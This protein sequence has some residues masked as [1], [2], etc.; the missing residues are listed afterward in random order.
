MSMK[1]NR[2]I[3][4][5]TNTKLKINNL[6]SEFNSYINHQ[7]DSV[8]DSIK[9]KTHPSFIK[10]NP[11]YWSYTIKSS[12]KDKYE[13]FIQS[14]YS[15]KSK[16]ISNDSSKT[17]LEK[18]KTGAQNII[19]IV[20][21]TAIQIVQKI[22]F[23]IV[24][25]TGGKID[26]A[27]ISKELF[28]YQNYSLIINKSVNNIVIYTTKISKNL[29]IFQKRFLNYLE[30]Y[31]DKSIS[32]EFNRNNKDLNTK[33]ERFYN[34]KK[35]FLGSFM[36]KTISSIK[37]IMQANQINKVN[38]FLNLP[39]T[40][41]KVYYVRNYF[42]EYVSRLKRLDKDSFKSGVKT[43]IDKYS[44]EN[45]KEK[46]KNIYEDRKKYSPSY[47]KNLIKNSTKRFFLKIFV[48]LVILGFSYNFIKYTMN[49]IFNKRADND[50][51]EALLLMKDL[52]KHNEE[53]MKFNSQI[54]QKLDKIN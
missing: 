27:K 6:K 5:I 1:F 16:L 12:I 36:L 3:K 22:N 8:N 49:K 14:I 32:N 54:L 40:L 4:G 45:I 23:I 37:F 21:T 35:A 2:L 9:K 34:I 50:L 38:K 48:Y 46:T 20:K 41:Q 52:K 18:T 39:K 28:N 19:N 29:V 15:G 30:K 47:I 10:T 13:K 24:K 11:F 43:S 51:K 17:S 53:L 42:S 44:Y 33:I 25:I 31:K 26:L 7:N